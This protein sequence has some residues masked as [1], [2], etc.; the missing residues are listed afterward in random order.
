MSDEIWFYANF[1]SF[2]RKCNKFSNIYKD[3]CY[4]F[5]LWLKSHFHCRSMLWW[6]NA[7]IIVK[8]GY[9]DSHYD[10]AYA[11]ICYFSWN[12]AKRTEKI[13]LFKFEISFKRQKS[14][15]KTLKMENKL[16]TVKTLL[17]C[18]NWYKRVFKFQVTF[19][20]LELKQK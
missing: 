7:S 4:K 17:K 8:M 2:L 14:K 9:F 19:S 1:E 15:K 18:D 3:W 10:G 20:T 13:H 16:H 12:L 11:S 5:P 6:S